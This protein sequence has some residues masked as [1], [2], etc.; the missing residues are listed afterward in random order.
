MFYLP[1]ENTTRKKEKG[2]NVK[3]WKGTEKKGTV[4]PWKGRKWNV[5]KWKQGKKKKCASPRL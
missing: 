4:K 1:I 5:W 2:E 3:E